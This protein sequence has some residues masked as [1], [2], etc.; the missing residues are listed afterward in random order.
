QK[1]QATEIKK[2]VTSQPLKKP[3]LVK[4]KIVE[5]DKQKDKNQIKNPFIPGSHATLA[6]NRYPR[7]GSGAPPQPKSPKYPN[8]N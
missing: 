1:K 2:R 7:G 3:T 5:N 4:K 8:T 6:L